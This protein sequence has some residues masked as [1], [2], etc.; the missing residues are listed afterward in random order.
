[1]IKIT[2]LED[3]RTFKKGEIIELNSPNTLLVG[4]NGCGKSTLMQLVWLNLPHE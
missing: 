3:L 4:D 2:F 1:M